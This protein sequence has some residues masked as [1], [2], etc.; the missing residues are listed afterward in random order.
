MCKVSEPLAMAMP[1]SSKINDLVELVPWSIANMYFLFATLFF[2]TDFTDYHRLYS[3][4]ASG[5]YEHISELLNRITEPSTG[6]FEG[7]GSFIVVLQLAL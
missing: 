3:V 4:Y 7:N 1:A 6:R 5:I 2:L